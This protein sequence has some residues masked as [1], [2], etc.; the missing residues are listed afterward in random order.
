MIGTIGETASVCSAPA[1]RWP[2]M[3]A[4]GGVTSAP[5]RLRDEHG[6]AVGITI[7]KDYVLARRLLLRGKQDEKTCVNRDQEV[8][9]DA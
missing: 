7:V 8:S 2:P 3:S 6:Y 9:P 4:C 1:R 5:E